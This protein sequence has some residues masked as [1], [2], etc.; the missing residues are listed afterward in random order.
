M[1]CDGISRISVLSLH[2]MIRNWLLDIAVELP[3]K[4]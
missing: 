1:L 4:I 2:E 3:E